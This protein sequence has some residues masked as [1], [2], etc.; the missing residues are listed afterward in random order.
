MKKRLAVGGLGAVA[1][2]FT[3]MIV[4]AAAE[5][6]L[7]QG[8]GVVLAERWGVVA[9]ADLY[10]GF[11]FVAAWIF[12]V[13]QRRRTALAWTV[14]L[15]FLGNLATILYLMVRILRSDDWREALLG[16]APPTTKVS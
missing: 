10:L 4:W 3:A 9:L 1:V 16:S 15:F 2:G 6:G 13:E 11:I 8:F 5:K 7:M 14:A 12:A